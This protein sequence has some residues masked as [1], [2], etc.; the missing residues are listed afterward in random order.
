MAGLASR[1]ETAIGRFGG[2]ARPAVLA[3]LAVWA[4]PAISAEGATGS[5]A[6]RAVSAGNVFG[7]VFG[8]FT[9]IL[10]TIFS[11]QLLYFSFGETFS[12][13]LL[14]FGFNLLSFGFNLLSF[15]FDNS[16]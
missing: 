11:D 16:I 10:R 2:L 3:G 1:D 9:R 12:F 15:G 4:V 13:D 6:G 7:G 14:R 8:I 5:L